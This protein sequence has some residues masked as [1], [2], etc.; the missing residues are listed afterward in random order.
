MLV[1]SYIVISNL[2]ITTITTSTTNA[3]VT[4]TTTVIIATTTTSID[5]IK[6]ELP[7]LITGIGRTLRHLY[8]SYKWRTRALRDGR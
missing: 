1:R 4:T 6:E 2:L 3:A 7:V 5:L 8:D